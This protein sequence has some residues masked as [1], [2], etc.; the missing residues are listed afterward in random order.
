[1]VSGQDSTAIS[2]LLSKYNNSAET[3]RDVVQL[4]DMYRGLSYA[5]ELYVFNDGS[6]DT[7][8]NIKGTIPIN[9]KNNTYNIPICIWLMSSHPNNA[10]ICYVKPTPD[11]R[12]KVSC[13]VDHNGKIYLPYLHDW[14]SSQENKSDLLGL[15]QVMIITFS[16]TPP[17][18]SQP[19][20]IVTPYPTQQ[21]F[22][23]QPGAGMGGSGY[24]PYPVPG[25]NFPPYPPNNYPRYP[26]AP[27]TF[28]SNPEYPPYNP[29]GYPPAPNY[30]SNNDTSGTGTITEQ[31]IKASLISAVQ[32]KL[33]R[34]INERVNQ[35]QAE[36]ET[37]NRTKMELSQGRAKIQM[38]ISKLE[39]EESEL[40][41]NI[42]VL[43]DKQE[44]LEK[45]LESIDQSNG[46]D[47][48]EAVT[49]T[50]PLYKQLLNAYAEEAAT[51]DA[52]YYMGEALRN[53]VIDLDLFLKQVRQMSRKQFMLRA[54]MQKCRQK[55]G[56]AG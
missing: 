27:T 11:M 13:F 32:D 31:H 53:G 45:S 28:P 7:L 56:L 22:M 6:S 8:F 47:V 5:S 37:L 19:R 54:L 9:Y 41:A 35:C 1:M 43:Q 52:I 50:A 20:E 18:Y 12:I 30:N 3:K 10:P 16:D 21:N 44:S 46:I 14:N 2:R 49:T 4:L 29:G 48:D 23:P 42:T 26:P 24:P 36:I 15:V 40:K 55:A 17:L 34:R 25:S 38:N 39:Q 33:R 51:E